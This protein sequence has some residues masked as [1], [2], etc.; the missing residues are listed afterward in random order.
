LERGLAQRSPRVRALAPLLQ[1][2]KRAAE[3][4]DAAVRVLTGNAAAPPPVDGDALLRAL[5]EAGVPH[6]ACELPIIPALRL[7]VAAAALQ[8]ERSDMTAAEW[9]SRVEE[10]AAPPAEQRPAA[11]AH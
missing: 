1:R 10:L 11:P 4:G 7:L 6:D 8:S 3:A 9:R 2:V 5:A